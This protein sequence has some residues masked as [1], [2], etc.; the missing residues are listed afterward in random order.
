MNIIIKEKVVSKNTSILQEYIKNNINKDG[1]QNEKYI[2]N[3]VKENCEQFHDYN[4][5]R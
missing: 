1:N 3:R 2:M 4:Q 5:Y